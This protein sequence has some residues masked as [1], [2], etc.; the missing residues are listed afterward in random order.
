M[1]SV[2][3]VV[4]GLHSRIKQYPN[5]TLDTCGIGRQSLLT[6]G[7]C[8]K[9]SYNETTSSSIQNG[10]IAKPGEWPWIALV[11]YHCPGVILNSNWIITVAH[12]I[13]SDYTFSVRTVQDHRDDSHTYGV[14]QVHY[15]TLYFGSDSKTDLTYDIALLKLKSQIL[16]SIPTS[17][18]D[19]RYHW[20]MAVNSICLPDKDIVN[21]DEELALTAGFGQTD[22]REYN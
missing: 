12:C 7:Q 8:F 2:V 17:I 15:L 3:I 11:I 16:I 13:K 18:G 9:W 20:S 4:N 22:E 5:V 14:Q 10:R 21:T 6:T 1:L 19:H